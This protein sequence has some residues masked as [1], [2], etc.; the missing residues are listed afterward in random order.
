MNRNFVVDVLLLFSMLTLFCF[1]LW[2]FQ[3]KETV[4][5]SNLKLSLEKNLTCIEQHMSK[6]RVF[7]SDKTGT[8]NIYY[9][10][11]IA[12]GRP[13]L[14]YMIEKMKEGHY[15]LN[16][17]VRF[18]TKTHFKGFDFPATIPPEKAEALAQ[19]YIQWWEVERKET[20]QLFDSL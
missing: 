3:D 17:A 20:P 19:K 12:L 1:S 15:A 5:S 10:R 11:I 6:N 13:A 14:P 2:S 9:R 18:L 7:L 4:D 16:H 8:A